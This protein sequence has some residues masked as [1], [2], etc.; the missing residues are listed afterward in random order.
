M[1]VRGLLKRCARC[2]TGG[3]FAGWFRMRDHCPGCGHVFEREEGFFLGAY[4]VNLAVAEGAVLLLAIVPYIAIR[5]TN[6]GFDAL[7]LLVAGTVGA[8]LGPVL[9]YPFS[10]TVWVAL[11]LLLR[12][13]EAAEPT[14]RR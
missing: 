8:I 6:P 14:D 9:F 7:P 12:P 3:L 11:D 10:R 4:V 1:L 5:A 2:G 13:S